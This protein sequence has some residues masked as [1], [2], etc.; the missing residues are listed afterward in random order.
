MGTQL[1]TFN[2]V[3]FTQ[4]WQCLYIQY[5]YEESVRVLETVFY[6]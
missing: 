6:L 4:R 2:L 3:T 1:V 5:R